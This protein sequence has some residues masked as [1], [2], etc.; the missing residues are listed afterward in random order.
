MVH[1]PVV[2]PLAVEVRSVGEVRPPVA[3]EE[4]R[5]ED[6]T[7]ASGVEEAKADRRQGGPAWTH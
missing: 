7:Q 5:V 6:V 2:D 4:G 1:D 3:S